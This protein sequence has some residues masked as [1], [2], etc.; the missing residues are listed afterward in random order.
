MRF[1]RA[2][3]LVLF[4]IL[5]EIVSGEPQG[6]GFQPAARCKNI[7]GTT[8]WPSEADWASLNQQV[9]GRLLKPPAPAAAC[10]RNVQST[11]APSC[12]QVNAG[13]GTHEFHI[14]HPTST[15]WQLWN[16]YS[17]PIS[18]NSPCTADGYPVYVVAAQQPKDVQAAVDFARKRNIRLN[19]KATGH[20]FLG[21]FVFTS[22]MK[23]SSNTEQICPT[24]VSLNLDA[25]NKRYEVVR[26]FF[27]ANRL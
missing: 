3:G 6:G 1:S 25:R 20:D 17:C 8:G 26:H 23:I 21:R 5:L 15:L 4:T 9:G 11:G 13:W 18:P 10:H 27:Y 12:A 16:N 22:D 14:N 19:I 24:K 7:P 2:Y